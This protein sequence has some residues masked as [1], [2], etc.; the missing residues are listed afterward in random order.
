[1]WEFCTKRNHNCV[2]AMLIMSYFNEEKGIKEANIRQHSSKWC[3]G[4]IS[5][6]CISQESPKERLAARLPWPSRNYLSRD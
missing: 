1:M 5:R 2:Y 6:S 4:P 3:R